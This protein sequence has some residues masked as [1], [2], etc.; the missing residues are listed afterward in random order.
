M[1]GL[2]HRTHRRQDGHSQTG[3]LAR[4]PSHTPRRS[5]MSGPAIALRFVADLDRLS[6]ASQPDP[7][8]GH[9]AARVSQWLVALTDDVRWSL[10]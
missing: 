1:G 7:A 3:G 4:T 9:P 6:P 8:S 5:A 10:S 2:G